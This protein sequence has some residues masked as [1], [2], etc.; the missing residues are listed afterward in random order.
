VGA[1]LEWTSALAVGV[2]DVDHQHQELFRRAERLVAALRGGDRGEVAPLLAFLEGYVNL[3]FEA[4]ERLMRERGYPGIED[5]AAAH[6]AFRLDFS[7][8]VL[9]FY[10]TGPTALVALTIHNWLSDWLRQ[11]I[12]EMDQELGRFLAAGGR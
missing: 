7:Q 11:H 9:D 6:Q 12:A 5:H 2:P 1:G 3:H 8:R 10:R 4:E